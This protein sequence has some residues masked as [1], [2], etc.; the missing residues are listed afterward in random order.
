[1]HVRYSR[2]LFLAETSIEADRRTERLR[3]MGEKEQA[4]RRAGVPMEGVCLYP[5]LSHLRLQQRSA[6]RQ[7]P[8]R[9]ATGP[10]AAIVR[11]PRSQPRCDASNGSSRACTRAN[12]IHPTD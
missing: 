3:H 5:M 10:R 11:V 9:D 12:L 2:P 4:S 6:L 7:R 1:M 8:D